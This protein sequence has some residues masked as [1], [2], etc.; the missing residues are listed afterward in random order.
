M[1]EK[2][3]NLEIIFKEAF[4]IFNM[5]NFA[6]YAKPMDIDEW[7]RY[8]SIVACSQHETFWAPWIVAKTISAKPS[9]ELQKSELSE[10]QLF[11]LLLQFFGNKWSDV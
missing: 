11:I 2:I 5:A 8:N 6:A 4:D 1:Y 7:K 9:T 10:S 3:G